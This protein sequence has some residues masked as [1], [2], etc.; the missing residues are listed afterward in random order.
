MK[1]WV[2][3]GKEDLRYDQREKPIPVSGEV[4]ISVSRVG[5]C[6]SDMSYYK[7]GKIGV[8]TPTRPFIIGHEFS[9]EICEIGAEVKDFKIG[10]RV[11]V[12]PS[13]PCGRCDYCRVGRY[14]LCKNMRYLGSA[15]YDPPVDGAF[16]EYITMPAE[17]CFKIPENLEYGIA[18]LMEPLSVATHALMRAGSLPGHSILITGAGT[19]GQLILI[20]A[21]AFGVAKVAVTD[22]EEGQR[23]LALKQG[24][25]YALDPSV[26]ELPDQIRE[27]APGGFDIVLEASGIVNA[28]R[29]GFEYVRDGGTIVQIG[30]LPAEEKIPIGKIMFKELKIVG[31]FRFCNVF[32]TAI[33]MAASGRINIEPLITQV[34]PFTKLTEAIQFACQ[35]NNIIKIQAQL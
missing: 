3:Y 6:G 28:L 26:A 27:I 21:R 12:E 25:D 15:M 29:Q 30:I 11:A 8:Y 14:N 34:F 4:L 9:G 5:I 16:C 35:G 7:T 19:I 2:L 32:H 24:A 10:D 22:P 33:E 31:S 18:A 20:L 13:M 17:N 23:K 1:A